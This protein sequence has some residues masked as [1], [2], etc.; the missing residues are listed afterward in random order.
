MKYL[1]RLF[2]FSNN[3]Q[4]TTNSS[5]ISL[6]PS[7]TL[8]S[9]LYSV[10]FITK[11]QL[12][13]KSIKVNRQQFDDNEEELDV[14]WTDEDYDD[15]E[16]KNDK[17]CQRDNR[18]RS[19]SNKLIIDEFNASNEQFITIN[20]INN[21]IEF[22]KSP[23]IKIKT[24]TTDS[25]SIDINTASQSEAEAIDENIINTLEASKN[26]GI[27]SS[28]SNY[29]L[30]ATI[31]KTIANTSGV[32][33]SAPNI[34]SKEKPTNFIIDRQQ[35]TTILIE[36]D[37]WILVDN[38]LILSNNSNHSTSFNPAQLDNKSSSPAKSQPIIQKAKGVVNQKQTNINQKQSIVVSENNHHNKRIIKLNKK[39][40]IRQM[41][42]D[43]TDV[44]L[45]KASWIPARKD[46]VFSG[47]LLFKG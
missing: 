16:F 20:T 47:V 44:E 14:F 31:G 41:A 27:I 23:S 30:T 3:R 6:K 7:A 1:N 17:Q 19:Q 45:I 22:E 32:I 46:P 39:S 21:S 5:S 2:A 37:D 24:K 4:E 8:A 29:I 10:T 15:N 28:L 26:R 42:L 33:T 38:N 35:D 34:E 40:I 36:E 18:L 11:P 43:N 13:S 9:T 25:S 12:N